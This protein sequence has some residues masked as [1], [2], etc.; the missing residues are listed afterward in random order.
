MNYKLRNKTVHCDS[1]DLD[2]ELPCSNTTAMIDFTCPYRVAA[3]LPAV[4]RAGRQLDRPGVRRV[5]GRL[6]RGRGHLQL[7]HRTHVPDAAVVD[8]EGRV[9]DLIDKPDESL[10]V[11]DLQRTRWA[12]YLLLALTWLIYF[13]GHAAMLV[14]RKK[15]VVAMAAVYRDGSVQELLAE[16]RRHKHQR[17]LEGLSKRFAELHRA[18]ERHEERM[19]DHESLVAAADVAEEEERKREAEQA[20]AEAL[21]KLSPSARARRLS[22]IQLVQEEPQL[23]REIKMKDFDELYE[24]LIERLADLEN[25]SG[26]W[27]AAPAARTSSPS[28]STRGAG[29]LPRRSSTAP[30]C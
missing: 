11:V 22:T 24:N 29:S 30:G 27:F 2:Y 21:K 4:G 10:P 20:E 17:E 26:N 18:V 16:G 8:P 14:L 9:D 7:Q 6:R 19:R 25:V 13:L 23:K 15:S 28:C 5:T 12:L 1:T 3:A